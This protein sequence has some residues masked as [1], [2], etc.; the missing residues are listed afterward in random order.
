MS[1]YNGCQMPED[2]DLYYDLD[3]IWARPE[4]DGT[5]TIGITDLAKTMSGRHVVPWRAANAL[6]G[7]CGGAQRGAARL[8]RTL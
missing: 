2:L 3:Y 8:D 4:E 5:F 1:E 7:G 6:C